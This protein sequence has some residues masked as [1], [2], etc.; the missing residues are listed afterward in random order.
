MRHDH[1]VAIRA[2]IKLDS[3]LWRYCVELGN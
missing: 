1:V 3:V 2:E